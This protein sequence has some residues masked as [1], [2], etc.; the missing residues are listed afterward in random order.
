MKIEFAII[1]GNFN[2]SEHSYELFSME[3]FICICNPQS[4]YSK[5]LYSLG[6]LFNETLILR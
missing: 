4:K 6:N 5:A 1:E 3:Y 2:K